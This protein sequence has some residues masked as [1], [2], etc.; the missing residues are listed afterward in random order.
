[1]DGGREPDRERI[2]RARFIAFE[3]FEVL[4]GSSFMPWPGRCGMAERSS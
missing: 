1:M 4:L 3:I 2:G